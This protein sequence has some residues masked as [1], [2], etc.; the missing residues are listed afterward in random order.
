M[1]GPLTSSVGA[2]MLH[3]IPLNFKN[4]KRTRAHYGSLGNGLI[5][6]LGKVHIFWEG[7]K[8]LR[9]SSRCFLLALHRTKVGWRFHKILWPSQNM[10]TLKLNFCEI[11]FI[12]RKKL[13]EFFSTFIG[14]VHIFWE[15]HKILRIFT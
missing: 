4:V 14:K 12:R 15:G 10:W 13:S 5:Y 2:R 1:I 7:Y 8:I 3:R 9:K 6:F 11:Y